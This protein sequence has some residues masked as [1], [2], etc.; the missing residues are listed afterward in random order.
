MQD[1]CRTP[2]TKLWIPDMIDEDAVYNKL[3]Q[4]LT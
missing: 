1:L 2:M 4:E 3:I